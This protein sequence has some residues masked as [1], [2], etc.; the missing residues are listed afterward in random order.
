MPGR[1]TAPHCLAVLFLW[2]LATEAFFSSSVSLVILV[3]PTWYF[4]RH[5]SVCICPMFFTHTC[6][7]LWGLERRSPKNKG[8]FFTTYLCDLTVLTSN[9]D[10]LA[11]KCWSGV[12]TDLYL[13]LLG[14]ESRR[15]AHRRKRVVLS[16]KGHHTAYLEFFCTDFVYSP[17]LF[18]SL[19]LTSPWT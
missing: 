12:S 15:T 2:P 9:L 7:A 19:L 3:T 18:I 4:T 5:R 16:L 1:P 8:L 10:C 11:E 13:I 14:R 17:Y 6:T